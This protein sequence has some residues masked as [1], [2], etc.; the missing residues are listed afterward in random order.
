MSPDVAALEAQ[1]Q[2]VL[3]RGDAAGARELEKQVQ[4]KLLEEQHV[5]PQSAPVVVVKPECAGPRLIADKKIFTDS[6]TASSADYEMDGTMWAAFAGASDSVIHVFKSTDH[7]QTWNSVS[8]FYIVPKHRVNKL[9]MVVGEGDSAFVY[10]FDMIP[11][12]N[13]DLYVARCDTNGGGLTSFAVLAGADSITDFTGC[14]DF[15]GND[16][17]VY[18]IAHNGMESG[19]Q[20]RSFTLRSTDYGKTWATTNTTYNVNR[21]RMAF[22]AGTFGYI[23][24]VPNQSNWKGW[25]IGG[26]TT[27]YCAPGKLFFNDFKPDTFQ[28]NDAAIAPAF[29]TPADSAITWVAY[30]QNYNNTSDWNVWSTYAKGDSLL[31]WKG[32]TVIANTSNPEGYVDLKNYASSGN[33]YVNVS[34]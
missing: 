11:N 28:I 25:V 4:A 18:A 12:N 33:T 34:Y 31:P 9:E 8:S 2:S 27:W 10:L 30:T 19:T 5:V 7:G 22:G 13:G 23:T 24:G 17:W 29:T 14:R 26:V 15:T 6:V 21:P 3:A 32:Y 20:P 1:V 16:Y